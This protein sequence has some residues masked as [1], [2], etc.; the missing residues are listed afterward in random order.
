WMP[1]SG[2]AEFQ[3]TFPPIPQNVTCLDFSEGDFEGAYKI[4]GIQLDKK[5]FSKFRLPKDV[6]VTK[7]DHKTTLPEPVVKYAKAV[8]KGRILD[9]QK[10][11]PNK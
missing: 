8:L 1:E 9:Y 10:G 4:W 5:T 7:A 3:L 11:M 6:T 2:E